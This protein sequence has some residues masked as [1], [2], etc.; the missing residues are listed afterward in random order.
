MY[1]LDEEIGRGILVP[2][3][4]HLAG[5]APQVELAGGAPAA[6]S[7]RLLHDLGNLLAVAGGESEMLLARVKPG[8]PLAE[9]LR[10]LNTAISE[11]VRLFRQFI[12]S[13]RVEAKEPGAENP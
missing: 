1:L 6:A 13:R 11:S 3:V 12:A 2:V 10:E 9:D 4:R 7:G 5:T 8:D